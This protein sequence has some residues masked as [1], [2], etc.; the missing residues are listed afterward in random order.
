[1]WSEFT[2]SF[3]PDTPLYRGNRYYMGYFASTASVT[4]VALQGLAATQGTSSHY[5]R[6]IETTLMRSN[7]KLI[8]RKNFMIWKRYIT[9]EVWLQCERDIHF[10]DQQYNCFEGQYF[11]YECQY[12]SCSIDKWC[13]P[14]MMENE[15]SIKITLIRNNNFT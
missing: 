13:K 2:V 12:S 6:K 14:K 11:L 3:C 9:F 7:L 15:F 4:R 10:I 5:S 8:K 1:M